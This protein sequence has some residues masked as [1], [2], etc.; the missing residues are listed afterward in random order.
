M[1]GERRQFD[2]SPGRTVRFIPACAGNASTR[3]PAAHARPVHPRMRGERAVAAALACAPVGSSPHARGTLL[4]PP[5]QRQALWFIPA[6]AG[7]ARA[8]SPAGRRL[9]VHPRMRGERIV[10]D[11][12]SS[13]NDGSSP[14]A[15][16]TPFFPGNVAVFPRFIPACA[17]NASFPNLQLER[18]S[19]HPRMRGERARWAMQKRTV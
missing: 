11:K 1:R 18:S 9:P 7:N 12:S 16:G 13:I 3:H 14:H 17:G 5:L 2:T 8:M 4:R 19:V 15:R 10:W 6:C